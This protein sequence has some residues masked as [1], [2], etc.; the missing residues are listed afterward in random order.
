MT[1]PRALTRKR[2]KAVVP[3]ESLGCDFAPRLGQPHSAQCRLEDLD[4]RDRLFLHRRPVEACEG[5]FAGFMATARSLPGVRHPSS[6]SDQMMTD[7]R[8]PRPKS[9]STV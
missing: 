8:A 6:S 1:A 3:L 2:A 4:G 7:P 5:V 9:T